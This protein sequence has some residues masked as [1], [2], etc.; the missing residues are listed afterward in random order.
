MQQGKREWEIERKRE[1]EAWAGLS[2]PARIKIAICSLNF[3][4]LRSDGNG[5]G[6]SV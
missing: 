1:R 3:K 5:G 2:R 6:G 4:L